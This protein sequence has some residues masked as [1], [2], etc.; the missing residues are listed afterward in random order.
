MAQGRSQVTRIVL[1]STNDEWTRLRPGSRGVLVGRRSTPFGDEMVDVSWDDGSTL[2][3]IAGVDKWH[4]E[5]E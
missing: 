2:S 4:E 3:L 5:D 1:V